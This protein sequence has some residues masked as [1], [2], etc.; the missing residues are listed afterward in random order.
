MLGFDQDGVLSQRDKVHVQDM[1][2]QLDRL[3]GGGGVICQHPSHNEPAGCGNPDCWKYQ[4]TAFI[5]LGEPVGC[6]S[7]KDWEQLTL[8]A[9]ILD[10]SD[11]AWRTQPRNER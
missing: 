4:E 3:N 1:Q 2:H 5:K 8:K 11:R 9:V 7:R 6:W 10:E